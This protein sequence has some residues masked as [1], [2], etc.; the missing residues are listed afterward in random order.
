MKTLK[1]FTTEQLE[2]LRTE[3]GKSDTISTS[4]ADRLGKFLDTL[5]Q[6]LW[7]QLAN[8]NIRFVS[9]LARNRLNRLAG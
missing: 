8:A 5:P 7:R 6:V 1:T 4:L 2:R 9:T 3:Y